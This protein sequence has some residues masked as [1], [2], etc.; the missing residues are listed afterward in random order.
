M[1]WLT[2]VSECL[3]LFGLILLGSGWSGS[4]TVTGAFPFH[5]SAV[6]LTGSATGMHALVGVPSLLI[7]L[8]LMV[9]SLVWGGYEAV[10]K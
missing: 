1:K 9:V 4:A 5:S 6:Q 7:G 8:G 2:M 3:V 10:T